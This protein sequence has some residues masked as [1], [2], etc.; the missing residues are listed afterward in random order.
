MKRKFVFK[1]DANGIWIVPQTTAWN[2]P[3]HSWVKYKIGIFFNTGAPQF[4]RL[5][6][7]IP[8]D[9][10]AASGGGV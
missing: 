6:L 3:K 4:K 2:N 7:F 5:S 1:N 10:G 9:T 8:A